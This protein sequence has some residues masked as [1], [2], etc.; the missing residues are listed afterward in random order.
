MPSK[1]HIF[2]NQSIINRIGKTYYKG[3]TKLDVYATILG[4]PSRG[5]YNYMCALVEVLHMPTRSYGYTNSTLWWLHIS[6]KFGWKSE[7]T[8][9]VKIAMSVMGGLIV[10]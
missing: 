7:H 3:L 2:K 5:W 1:Q 6:K 10:W 4:M 9:T 8:Y